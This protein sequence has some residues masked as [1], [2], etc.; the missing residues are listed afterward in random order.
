[1]GVRE[2]INVSDPTAEKFNTRRGANLFFIHFRYARPRPILV[3]CVLLPGENDL[4]SG[5]HPRKKHHVEIEKLV[6]GP[7]TDAKTIPV[8]PIH[9]KKRRNIYPCTS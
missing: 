3:V 2:R 1:L 9:S 7:G 6:S 8:Q 4:P 5:C